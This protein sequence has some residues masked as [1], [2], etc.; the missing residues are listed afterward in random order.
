MP[1]Q[2]FKL[3]YN[4]ECIVAIVKPPGLLLHR[5]RI[6]EDTVFVLQLL[7]DQLGQWVY[8]V[9]RLDRATGGVL[10][11][12]KDPETAEALG[13]Q[14][15]TRSVSKRYEAIVRGFVEAE[16]CIDSPLTDERGEPQ[17]ALTRY[18]RLA[19]YEAPVPVGRYETARYSWVEVRPETGRF[20]QI[21]RHFAH[22]RHPVVGCKKHGDIHHNAFFKSLFG[23][24]AL[25]LHA[26]AL[27]FSHP[28]TGQAVQLQAPPSAA[29][30]AALQWLAPHERRN[31]AQ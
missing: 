7:R 12:A 8:P 23:A 10:L 6:S 11:L 2:P 29:F 24:N 3:L 1:H 17:E 26:A 16:G 4:D 27:A 31:E 30:E 25:M 13:Q 15:R 14:F 19:Q 9:H 18:R 21:R 28:Q 5:T 20:H 22:I